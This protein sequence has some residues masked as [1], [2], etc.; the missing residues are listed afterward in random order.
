M[1]KGKCWTKMLK[2]KTDI[3]VT[4]RN[5][6]IERTSKFYREFYASTIPDRKQIRA[7]FR[8]IITEEL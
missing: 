3:Q 6:I 8:P 2:S 1:S 5:K 7:I 4:N